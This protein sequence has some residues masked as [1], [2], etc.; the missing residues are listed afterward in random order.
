MQITVCRVGR[1]GSA[2][3][4]ATPGGRFFYPQLTFSDLVSPWLQSGSLYLDD[5]ESS[6]AS[7]ARASLHSRITV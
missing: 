7:H 2:E 6:R 1:F 5:C 3:I 4:F